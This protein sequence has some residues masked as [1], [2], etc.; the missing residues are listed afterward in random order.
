[1]ILALYASIAISL[2]LGRG[3]KEAGTQ[4]YA[5]ETIAESVQSLAREQEAPD[6][7][8]KPDQRYAEV[9]LIRSDLSDCSDAAQF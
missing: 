7:E 3:C 2:V 5:E 4:D 8:D 9:E 1:L 6:A